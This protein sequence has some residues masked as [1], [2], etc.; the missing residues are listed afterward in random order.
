MKDRDYYAEARAVIEAATRCIGPED[1]TITVCFEQLEAEIASAI[2][3][4]V[5]RASHLE[6]VIP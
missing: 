3:R 2:R 5:A 6:V 1:R 4:E